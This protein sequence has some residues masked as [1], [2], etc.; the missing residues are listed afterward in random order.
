LHEA[1]ALQG[2]VSFHAALVL[3]RVMPAK[4]RKASFNGPTAFSC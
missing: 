3:L 4:S 1:I 2:P